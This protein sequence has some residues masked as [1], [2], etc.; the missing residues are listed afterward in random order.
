M[1]RFWMNSKWILNG[2]LVAGSGTA[3]LILSGFDW[4]LIGFW[5]DS[6]SGHAGWILHGF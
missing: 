1:N 2:F 6:W 4:I 5:V 3:R